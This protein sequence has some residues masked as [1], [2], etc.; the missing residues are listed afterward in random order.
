MCN[1]R[2][3]QLN[4]MMLR[5]CTARTNTC[6]SCKCVMKSGNKVTSRIWLIHWDRRSHMIDRL[7]TSFFH[8][9][10]HIFTLSFCVYFARNPFARKP[11]PNL[12]AQ[13]VNSKK[14]LQIFYGIQTVLN[15]YKTAILFIYC[16][17]STDCM[18]WHCVI[19]HQNKLPWNNFQLK[20]YLTF[21]EHSSSIAN[22]KIPTLIKLITVIDIIQH[23]RKP[24]DNA[25]IY[26]ENVLF[27]IAILVRWRGF[28]RK[29]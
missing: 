10:S 8:S 9:C 7:I 21:G 1:L 18:F 14:Y 16:D 27:V 2:V 4:R 13:A 20:I 5:W 19:R 22:N 17:K 15:V 11:I 6:V 29:V 26:T 3:I 12:F 24:L 25:M 23:S 28:T